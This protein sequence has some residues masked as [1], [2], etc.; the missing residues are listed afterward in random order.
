MER[1]FFREEV[2]VD[3]RGIFE[4]FARL[5][6]LYRNVHTVDTTEKA[7]KGKILKTFNDFACNSAIRGLN[8]IRCS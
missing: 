8:C 4:Q 7:Q 5:G 1:L 2:K 3:K 6:K